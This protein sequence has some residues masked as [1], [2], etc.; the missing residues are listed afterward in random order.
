MFYP[1]DGASR[2]VG[3]TG[4]DLDG[5]SIEAGMVEAGENPARGVRALGVRSTRLAWGA[6]SP[7][8]GGTDSRPESATL[9]K[10]EG[11]EKLNHER[12]ARAC[13][14]LRSETVPNREQFTPR[15]KRA[16]LD[17][18]CRNRLIAETMPRREPGTYG[19]DPWADPH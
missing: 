13:Q 9:G 5:R 1:M 4:K 11:G 14:S 16:L 3:A 15:G 7:A 6:S 2:G 12:P 10:S 18:A 17:S 8:T 19:V